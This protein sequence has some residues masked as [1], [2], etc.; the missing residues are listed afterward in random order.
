MLKAELALYNPLTQL[1]KQKYCY[2]NGKKYIKNA[3][4]IAK[5][6]FNNVQ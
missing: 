2:Q 4:N 5:P 6:L 3:S 1:Q